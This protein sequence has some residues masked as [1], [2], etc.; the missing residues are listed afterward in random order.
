MRGRRQMLEL[1]RRWDGNQRKI[2]LDELME[3]LA[4][5]VITARDLA[6]AVGFDDRSYLRTLIHGQDHYQALVLCWRSGQC[7]PIH[8][9]HGSNC[10]VRVVE[11]VAT[12]TRF[13]T[14]PC[15]RIRPVVSEVHGP[16]S[17]TG[18]CGDEIHQM[19]NLES[20]GNELITLH[21]YSPPPS[22][23]RT[24]RVCDTTLAD[25]D[26]LIRKPARTVRVELGHA[27]PARRMGSTTRGGISWRA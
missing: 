14:A 27:A 10:A 7:S 5:L 25:D 22:S 21:V 9:H 15:G 13:A 6:E 11:G 3:A 18:C 26:R 4:A 2:P 20:P 8:D 19:A 16:R 24:Y 12:E 1:I 23:W 17:V